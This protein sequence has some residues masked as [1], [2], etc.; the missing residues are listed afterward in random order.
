[1]LHSTA[2]TRP[3]QGNLQGVIV[4]HTEGYTTEQT[5]NLRSRCLVDF[6]FKSK[7]KRI[8][9][10]HAG[11]FTHQAVSTPSQMHSPEPSQEEEETWEQE[12]T[13]FKDFSR[14]KPV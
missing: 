13:F 3:D 2:A 1:M 6:T 7:L 9:V 10:V 4:T 5:L 12:E 8:I 14:I 11:G